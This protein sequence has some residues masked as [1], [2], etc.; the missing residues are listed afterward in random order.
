[1]TE[2]FS[3]LKLIDLRLYSQLHINETFERIVLMP[4]TLVMLQGWKQLFS[5]ESF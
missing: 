2:T 4:V 1:M 3:N 5:V